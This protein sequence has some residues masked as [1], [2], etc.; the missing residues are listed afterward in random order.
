MRKIGRQ[1]GQ[2]ASGALAALAL[3]LTLLFGCRN[4]PSAG[5]TQT[6]RPTLVPTETP[7]APSPKSTSIPTATPGGSAAAPVLAT[8][9]VT[10]TNVVVET[11]LASATNLPGHQ[12]VCLGSSDVVPSL[13]AWKCR[14]YTPRDDGTDGADPCLQQPD[15]TLV[16]DP[17]GDAFVLLSPEPLPA[18]PTA[19]KQA[20]GTPWYVVIPVLSGTGDVTPLDLPA[21]PDARDHH[22]EPTCHLQLRQRGCR[23]WTRRPARQPRHRRRMD[24]H[25]RP[26]RAPRRRMGD[27]VAADRT[28]E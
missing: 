13:S 9:Q 10:V 1:I 27:R 4:G 14:S 19:A 8:A 3:A 22:R 16:C 5:P 26:R 2:P 20:T 18:Q 28:S 15:G 7:A 21:R 17:T 12:G 23:R 6:L 25:A 24:G 11:A